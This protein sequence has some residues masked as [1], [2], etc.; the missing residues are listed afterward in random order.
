MMMMM[1]TMM[2]AMVIFFTLKQGTSFGSHSESNLYI[3]ETRAL[4]HSPT[5]F[6]AAPL[7]P[8]H[9]ECFCDRLIFGIRPARR[10]APQWSSESSASLAFCFGLRRLRRRSRSS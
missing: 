9:S 1:L 2:M 8:H 6:S 4:A 3:L 5:T 10:Q 7:L